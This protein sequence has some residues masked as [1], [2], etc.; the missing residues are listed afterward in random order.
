LKKDEIIAL[1]DPNATPGSGKKK[2][3]GDSGGGPMGGMGAK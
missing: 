1:A 3:K 2:E